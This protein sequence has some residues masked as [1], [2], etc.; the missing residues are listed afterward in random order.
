MTKL[1]IAGSQITFVTGKKND[2]F[3]KRKERIRR[4]P[5]PAAPSGEIKLFLTL[6]KK[7]M[8]AQSD[9]WGGKKSSSN[10]EGGIPAKYAH[11]SEELG[12]LTL[13]M[14]CHSE[15]KLLLITVPRPG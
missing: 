6:T 14:D 15:R 2:Y 10:E 12:A 5:Y 13:K 9:G 1:T 4:N 7:S 3:P 11:E 8:L